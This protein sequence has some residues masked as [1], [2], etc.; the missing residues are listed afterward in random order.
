MTISRDAQKF[1][2]D[3]NDFYLTLIKAKDLASI[4]YVSQRGVHEEEGAVQ[5]IL[6]KTRINGIRDFLLDGGFFPNV[7]ILNVISDGEL[8]YNE[9]CKQITFNKL[10]KIAQII[11]G[12]HRIEGIKEAIK[13]DHLIEDVLVP[14]VLTSQLSTE[15]CAKIFISINTEQKS[16]PK[17]LIYDLYGLINISAKDFSIERGADIAKILNTQDTSPYQRY[18]KFPGSRKFKGGIQ[19]STFVN[20]LKPLVKNEGEFSRYGLTTLENQTN[21]LKNYLNA[22]Q[23]CYGEKWYLLTNPF[24]Y[25]SGF[26]AA[27]DVLINKILP[28]CYSKKKFSEVFF[29][30]III[31][32]QDKLI[33]QTEVRGMS[34]EIARITI[35]KRLTTY[36][37][38]QVTT[39]DDFEI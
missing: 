21:I 11:D 29:K 9:S 27:I 38:I 7:L 20:S 37:R 17:S 4:S 34:G 1:S 22:I 26:G 8:L 33:E 31:I 2:H 30:E 19:L 28:Y 3:D 39:E 18:I 16:V 13:Q 15:K 12:Q 36:I 5:R 23:F 25:A 10:P 24:I 32:P 35:Q 6:N 14:T